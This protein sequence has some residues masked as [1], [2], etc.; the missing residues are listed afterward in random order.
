MGDSG[1]T[2]RGGPTTLAPPAFPW[3]SGLASWSQPPSRLSLSSLHQ[4][5]GLVSSSGALVRIQA[6]NGVTVSSSPSSLP[7]VSSVPLTDFCESWNSGS[8]ETAGTEPR[9]LFWSYLVGDS[10]WE[11]RQVGF[12]LNLC[13][14]YNDNLYTQQSNLSVSRAS[15]WQTSVS[16]MRGGG[17]VPG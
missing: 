11:L 8:S 2:F 10:L 3:G 14:I 12:P 9:S 1:C 5:R 4:H 15:S 16:W 13:P 7:L 6:T 17:M